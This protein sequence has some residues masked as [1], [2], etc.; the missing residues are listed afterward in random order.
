[1]LQNTATVVDDAYSTFMSKV[2]RAPKYSYLHGPKVIL[3]NSFIDRRVFHV[4]LLYIQ[5]QDLKDLRSKVAVWPSSTVV[6]LGWGYVREGWKI[7]RSRVEN[8][9]GCTFILEH[10]AF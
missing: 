8:V 5:Q 7:G 6:G 2:C 10:Q 9:N 4:S 1:M 3:Y